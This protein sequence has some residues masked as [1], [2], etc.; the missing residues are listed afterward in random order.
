MEFLAQLGLM[1][2][3]AE[4][5]KLLDD[6]FMKDERKVSEMV[7]KI[8]TAA[9]SKG[10]AELTKAQ[11]AVENVPQLMSSSRVQNILRDLRSQAQTNLINVEKK[12]N[13]L[14]GDINQIE[15]QLTREEGRSGIVKGITKAFGIK[16][17][18]LTSAENFAKDH[19]I[20]YNAIEQSV[21]DK[22]EN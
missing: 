4:S 1:L 11:H 2:G 20:D 19:G 16:S 22:K 7:K 14:E 10:Q 15:N 3:V 6:L 13:G 9:R 12:V 8:L 5:E 17:D 21:N 18:A